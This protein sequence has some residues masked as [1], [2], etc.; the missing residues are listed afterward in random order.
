MQ[1]EN[2]MQLDEWRKKKNLSYVQLA[3][4]LGASHATVVRRWCLVGEHK[5]KMIPSPKFMRIISE[6][7][8]GEVSANDFYK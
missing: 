6:S 7:T 2:F 4:K 8:F 5:D 1:E 3:K